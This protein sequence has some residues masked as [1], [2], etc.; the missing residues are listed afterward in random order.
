MHIDIAPLV[1]TPG[2]AAILRALGGSRDNRIVGGAVRDTL[3]GRK[4]KDVDLATCLRPDMV[5]A[6]L[7]AAGI[8]AI[9]TGL[10]HGVVTAVHQGEHVEITTLRHDV[11]TDGR[12]AR[13]VYTDDWR[14]DAARRD[15]TLNALFAD[16]ETGVVSDFFGGVEDAR[17][18]RVRFI[19]DPVQRIA[20]DRL[21][22]LRFFRF[23]A[24]YGRGAPDAAGL[25]ACAA[26][27]GDMACLS[28][29]RIRDEI[30]KILCAD[31]PVPTLG[32]MLAHAI[33]TPV[34][35]E[36]APSRLDD[37]SALIGREIQA[38]VAP[39]PIRRLSSLISPAQDVRRALAGR[40]RLSKIEGKRLIALG[41][42]M[43]H[44]GAGIC[45]D[46]VDK[47]ADKGALDR[48]AYRHGVQ[49]ALDRLLLAAGASVPLQAWAAYL[50]A[51]VRPSLPVSGHD[52]ISMGVAPGRPLGALLSAIEDEWMRRGFPDDRGA[53]LDFA[54]RHIAAPPDARPPDVL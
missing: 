41:P 30:C 42:F 9:P 38:G 49:G 27:A 43:E 53:L 10:D 5:M 29:E 1:S 39:C 34:V 40:L 35:P 48:L 13:V 8:K 4:V 12:H 15:F 46:M 22:I 24:G 31:N 14:A 33:L 11:E 19:G 51:W 20:E 50:A 3:L 47:G 23:H 7:E 26:H 52:L 44:E 25:A 28:A 16:P 54:A 45:P 36:I 6:R 18:G 21:R 17:C 2:R 37:L 32:V